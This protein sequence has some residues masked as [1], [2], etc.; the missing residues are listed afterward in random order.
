[1]EEYVRVLPSSFSVRSHSVHHAQA[2]V[3]AYSFLFLLA[4]VKSHNISF[5]GAMRLSVCL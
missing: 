4:A 5:C 1:M 2:G 3:L